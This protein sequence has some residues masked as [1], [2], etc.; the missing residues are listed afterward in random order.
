MKVVLINSSFVSKP[1]DFIQ[2]HVPHLRLGVASIAAYLR[3]HGCDVAIAD[4]QVR[5][6]D[7]TSAAEWIHSMHPDY[8]GLSSHTEEIHDAAAIATAIKR[9]DPHIQ[10][11]AG[12]YHVSALPAETLAEFEGFDIGVIG[13]GELPFQALAENKPRHEIP[14]IAYR[15]ET[16]RIIVNEPG[17]GCASLDALPP[18]A[19]DLYDLNRYPRGLPIEFIRSCPFSCV[20]CFKTT[21]RRVRY[22]SPER[23]LDEVEQCIAR[24]GTRDF[25]FHSSGT[26]PLNKPHGMEVCRGV[27]ARGLKI[28]WRTYTRVDLLD[29]ELLRAMKE[30]GCDAINLGVESGDARVLEACQKGVTL[31]LAE[32]TVKLCHKVGLATELNFILGLPHETRDS[33]RNTMAFAAKLRDYSTLAN[34]AI[35]VPFPGTGIYTMASRHEN[36]MSLRTTDWRLYTKHAGQALACAQFAEHE[37]KQW[38]TRMYLSYYLGSWRKMLQLFRSHAMLELLD[39]RRILSVLRGL[40]RPGNR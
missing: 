4:P 12:G 21:G 33:L 31:E 23:A 19:W 32:H 8:V 24:F 40:W 10:T 39:A 20:F 11:V 27:L 28:R 37:L 38:Q 2:R 36:G 5:G 15:D 30:S 3:E 14:G 18:P 34:F 16:G 6:L 35:L 29:E 13:E 25:F 9:L 17:P 1:R 22:K 7:A 26:F